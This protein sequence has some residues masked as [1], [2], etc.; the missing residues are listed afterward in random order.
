M[1]LRPHMTTCLPSGGL[2]LRTI[3][4]IAPCHE[5][6]VS[7]QHL[8]NINRMKAIHVFGWIDEIQHFIRIDVFW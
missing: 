3:N 4:S 2:P 6:G 7:D 8:A 1:L 5:I